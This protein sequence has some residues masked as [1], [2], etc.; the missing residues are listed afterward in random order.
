MIDALL[1]GDPFLASALRAAAMASVLCGVLGTFVVLRR[2]AFLSGGISHAAFG[3]L[4]FCHWLGVAPQWGGLGTAVAAAFFLGSLSSARDR[5]RDALVG[6]LWASGMASG[7]LFIH[8]APGYPPDLG[9]YLFGNLL[10]VDQVSLRW[11]TVGSLLTLGLVVW[12]YEDLVALCFDET[13]AAVQGVRVRWLST[14]LLGL[15]ALA[16]VLLLPVVGLL[17]VLAMLTI[18]PLAALQISHRLGWVL[19]LSVGFS[20][21]M[22]FGGLALSFHWDAPSGPC[23]ILLGTAL[24]GILYLRGILAQ[25]HSLR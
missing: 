9:A 4:G 10:L 13:F 25:R 3:G 24:L 7:M 22:T 21:L 6:V 23:I 12:L 2:L 20:I 19:L 17:L 16:V 18:P 8:L 14:L 5:T 15:V 11:L 1:S